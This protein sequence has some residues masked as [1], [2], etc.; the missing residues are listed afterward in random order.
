M[1]TLF[2]S[3]LSSTLRGP[4]TA[5]PQG[6]EREKEKERRKRKENKETWVVYACIQA[7]GGGRKEKRTK[8]MKRVNLTE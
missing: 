3:A 4:T 1:G 7:N 5:P 2:I 8:N 6:R